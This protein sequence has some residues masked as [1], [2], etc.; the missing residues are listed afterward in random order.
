MKPGYQTTEFYVALL[1][2]LGSFF[3]TLAGSLPDRYAALASSISGGLYAVSRGL[4]KVYP[5]KPGP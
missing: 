1:V 2:I 5:P 3:A 4:A